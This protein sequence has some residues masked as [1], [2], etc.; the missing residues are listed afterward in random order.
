MSRMNVFLALLMVLAVGCSRS[1]PPPAK[2]D[3]SRAALTKALDAWKAGEA[4]PV[5]EGRSIT[6][7]DDRVNKGFELIAYEL[8]EEHALGYD[9]QIV[10]KMTM[11]HGT[12]RP[13]QETIA[14]HVRTRPD[15]VISL[16]DEE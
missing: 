8:G 9:R 14:Y 1:A 3:E 15:V 11:R 5:W 12:S 13:R 7:R 4:N 6:L 2:A 16:A 10:V